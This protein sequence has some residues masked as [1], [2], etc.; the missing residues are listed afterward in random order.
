M[1]ACAVAAP[2]SRGIEPFDKGEVE[3]AFVPEVMVYNP[4][5]RLTARLLGAEG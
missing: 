4:A 2:E 3:S 1:M 5:P